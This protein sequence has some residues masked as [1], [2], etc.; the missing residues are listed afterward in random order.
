MSQTRSIKQQ[1]QCLLKF[2]IGLY[3]LHLSQYFVEQEGCSMRCCG[4][5]SWGASIAGGVIGD[6]FCKAILKTEKFTIMGN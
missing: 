1:S 6:N 4:I 3:S 5:S 2:L